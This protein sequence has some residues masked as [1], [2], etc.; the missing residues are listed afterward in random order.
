MSGT[1]LIIEDEPDVAGLM[2][3]ALTD[4]GYDV[5]VA[6]D[7]E[8]GLDVFAESGFDAVIVDVVLPRLQG[9]D[10]LPRLRKLPRGADVPVVMV[11]GGIRGDAH[12]ERMQARHDI[13]AYLHKPVD[14]QRLKDVLHAETSRPEA[15]AGAVEGSDDGAETEAVVEE[16][17]PLSAPLQG[18]LQ[19]IPFARL[20]GAIYSQRLTGALMLRKASVKKLVYFKDGEPVFVKS[21]LLHE[22]LGRIMVAE[23]LISQDECDQ[24]LTRKQ[25]EPHKR[26]GEL[27]IE[28]GSISPHN[29]AFGL[30]LQMQAKLF[31]IFSWLEGRYQF[32]PDVEHD[33]EPIP[34][35]M[36]PALLIYE[37][38]SRAMSTERIRRDLKFTEDWMLVPARDAGFRYQA[39]QLDPRADRFLDRVDGTRSAEALITTGEL[40]PADASVVLYALVC[41]SLVRVAFGWEGPFP[42]PEVEGP[43]IPV[44]DAKTAAIA[45]DD[46]V[47]VA[48]VLGGP[49]GLNIPRRVDGET[50]PDATA[51]LEAP[52]SERFADR[53]TIGEHDQRVAVA[54]VG[55]AEADAFSTSEDPLSTMDDEEWAHEI[56]AALDKSWAAAIEPGADRPSSDLAAPVN[57]VSAEALDD[58]DSELDD[59]EVVVE[60]PVYDEQELYAALGDDDDDDDDHT[61]TEDLDGVAGGRDVPMLAA[62]DLEQLPDDFVLGAVPEVTDFSSDTSESSV[63]FRVP[64]IEEWLAAA[65]PLP[66]DLVVD[67]RVPEVDAYGRVQSEGQLKAIQAEPLPE[68]VILDASVHSA[69]DDVFDGKPIE[70]LPES[71]VYEAP[72][73]EYFGPPVLI[74]PPYA[75]AAPPELIAFG[76]SAER[77]VVDA[78]DPS[79]SVELEVVAP[80][81]PVAAASSAKTELEVAD[82]PAPTE[83]ESASGIDEAVNGA[84]AMTAAAAAVPTRDEHA[85]SPSATEDA[86]D[87]ALE[88]EIAMA[89]EALNPVSSDVQQEADALLSE[90]TANASTELPVLTEEA[91]AEVE[92]PIESAPAAVAEPLPPPLDTGAEPITLAEVVSP[93]EREILTHSVAAA[94]AEHAAAPEP[95]ASILADRPPPPTVPDNVDADIT[96]DDISED[97]WL[98][99]DE[100][101]DPALYSPRTTELDFGRSSS[102]LRPM[103]LS[104]LS[105]EER[106]RTEQEL[107]EHLEQLGAMTHYEVLQLDPEANPDEIR[108]AR[109]RLESQFHPDRWTPDQLT[110]RARRLAEQATLIVRR[111]ADQLLSPQERVRYDRAIGVTL[112][113]TQADPF[114]AEI[115]Y[116][117]GQAAAA[118][119][120]QEDAERQFRR[121][122]ER[123]PHEGEY[124]AALAETL[125]ARDALDEASTLLERAT[126]LS[127][128]SRTVSLARARLSRQRSD[129]PAAI[130][131]YGKVLKID[132]D[133]SEAREFLAAQDK[134]YVRRTG[135]LSRLTK[136]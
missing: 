76:R 34:M 30:E 4:D 130:E 89:L 125:A 128:S 37:G 20:L 24:S 107:A 26:Q 57:G 102:I 68:S 110:A 25:A 81:A 38:A 100:E 8:S 62:A 51:D 14:L 60:E 42:V 9:F 64:E 11:S 66:E 73:P 70:P 54:T 117:L 65:D 94:S 98:S 71:V 135:L 127:P 22:C 13:A 33:G 27:L 61:L 124:V 56:D 112:R 50:D 39:L 28:M 52:R 74:P 7:G 122:M 49:R 96:D 46:E 108:E 31:D 40:S 67:E 53:A 119:K 69:M 41:T 78:K 113:P 85:L 12:A 47:T 58:D 84:A 15:P 21:N 134:L 97:V 19:E 23:R 2:R 3:D 5:V 32:N 82:S 92:P 123:A 29:L 136:A 10:L 6:S 104:E 118:R 55:S 106:T 44:P 105:E 43:V 131:W 111:A 80:S 1:V 45:S 88:G 77:A 79:S 109:A 91:A 16:P 93:D 17:A 99:D 72:V 95:P 132:P 133:C 48:R 126:D 36:G 103:A 101:I 129:N 75:P 87:R 83:V 116:Q 59:I 114:E 63:V 18:E 90:M 35:S 115:A 86:E 120:E 121:A